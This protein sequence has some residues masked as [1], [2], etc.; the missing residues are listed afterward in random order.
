MGHMYVIGLTGTQLDSK[1]LFTTL[2]GLNGL[3][4]ESWGQKKQHRVQ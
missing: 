1:C 2:D 3:I 4:I